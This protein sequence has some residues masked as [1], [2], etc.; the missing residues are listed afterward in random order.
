M[1]DVSCGRWSAC[2]EELGR[3]VALED[4][5]WTMPVPSRTWRKWSFPLERLL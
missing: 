1:I 4:D 5:A 3:H 2:G